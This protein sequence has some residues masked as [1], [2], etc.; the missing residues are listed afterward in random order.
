MKKK[1]IQLVFNNIDIISLLASF[2]LFLGTIEYLIPKPIPIKIGLANLPI[3]I[4]LVILK[5]KN[6]FLLII[7]KVITQGIVSGTFFSY[8]FLNSIVGSI[9]SGIIMVL[10]F[11]IFKNKISLI[12]ISTLGALASNISQI[13]IM[14]LFIFGEGIWM[15]APIYLIIGTISGILI[16]LIAEFFLSKSEWIKYIKKSKVNNIKKLKN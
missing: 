5:P 2:C 7:L 10:C 1:Q 16:G 14:K 12:G 11:N 4:A 8:I 6:V 13:Y 9:S 15:I 3:L